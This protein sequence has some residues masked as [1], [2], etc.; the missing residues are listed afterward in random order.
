MFQGC[1]KKVSRVSR[2]IERLELLVGFKAVLNSSMGLL[3]NIRR[4]FRGC[5]KEFWYKRL[6]FQSV[7]VCL[8]TGNDVSSR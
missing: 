7:G 8:S 2:K 1:Y 3:G 4:F 6:V 5:L